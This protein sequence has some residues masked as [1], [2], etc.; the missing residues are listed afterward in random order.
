MAVLKRIV[1][2]LLVVLM[3]GCRRGPEQWGPFRGQVIDAET[4][5]SIAGA[6]VMVSWERDKPNPVHWTQSFYD[7]QET[8]TD[9]KG[10]FEIPRETRF[11]TVFVSQPRVS[12]FAPGFVAES[13]E[14]T[15]AGGRLYVDATILKMRP[16][17]TREQRCKYRPG[18]PSASRAEVPKFMDA[19]QQYNTG[20]RCWEL[21]ESA[22]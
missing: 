7:A 8:V 15:P 18:E 10:Q 2:C 5:M 4:G 14:V 21:P 6:N 20:L 11:L 9:M 3:G 19:V 1:L 17:K 22:R 12:V 13:E 16:L